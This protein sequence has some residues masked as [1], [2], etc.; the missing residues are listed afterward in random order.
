MAEPGVTNFGAMRKGFIHS[1][2]NTPLIRLNK[3]SELTGCEIYGKA[4]FLNLG[5][6]VKDRAALYIVRDAEEKGLL[7]PGGVIVEG[8]ACNTGIGLALVG[9]AKGYK[10]V[11]MI[12]KTQS[13]E[14]KDMLRISGATLVEVPVF[15]NIANRQAHYK[16][17]GQEIWA[18]TGGKID[19]FICAIGTGGTLP[20][21]EKYLK[22]KNPNIGMADPMGAAIQA[23]YKTTGQEIWAQTGGK[24]DGFICAIGTGGTLPGVEKYLK[25]KNPN[26]GM[27][28]PMGAA[29]YSYYST[30]VLEST[31]TSKSEGIGQG[32]VTANLDG[33]VEMLIFGVRYSAKIFD[34]ESLKSKNLPSPEWMV[35]GY[36]EIDVPEVFE[37]VLSTV[38]LTPYSSLLTDEE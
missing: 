36:K 31:G 21:V 32:R 23:H 24:I 7:K 6:S 30:G 3:V 38:E 16:T 27:A 29:M 22:E 28:D 34:T 17:T 13:Q 37:D 11:I 10:T 5:G 15:D 1:I 2:G 19:G 26:I 18:Q 4:A 33:W 20:G 12:P 35:P 14:K 9:N 25:E 8:T